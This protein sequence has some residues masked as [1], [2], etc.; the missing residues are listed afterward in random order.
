[1]PVSATASAVFKPVWPPRVGRMASGRS[2]SMIM[3]T[4]SGVM[5]SM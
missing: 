2:F 1:M 3:H 5:G 4:T